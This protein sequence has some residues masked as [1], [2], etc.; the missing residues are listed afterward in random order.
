[1][2]TMQTMGNLLIKMR[3]AAATLEEMETAE[4]AKLADMENSPEYT[5]QQV[6]L[7]DMLT[8]QISRLKNE[9][10]NCAEALATATIAFE[11]CVEKLDFD[12]TL[13]QLGL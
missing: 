6:D 13:Q 1:M 12:G 3:I 2:T 11:R 9:L 10:D 7:Q 8:C 5:E 4:Y